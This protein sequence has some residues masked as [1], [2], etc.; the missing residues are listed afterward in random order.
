MLLTTFLRTAH[1]RREFDPASKKDL[2]EL[3]FFKENGK[4]KNGCPFYLE[5]PFVEIPAMCESRYTKYM[6][7]K[8]T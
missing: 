3:K 8:M 4:W 6:L 1:Q 7:S 5:D 2:M